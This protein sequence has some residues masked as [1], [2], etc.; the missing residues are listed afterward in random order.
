VRALQEKAILARQLAADPGGEEPRD[1]NAMADQAQR[2]AD[3]L[4]AILE[5]SPPPA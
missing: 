2:R 1:Y 5:Q 4:R 3:Q